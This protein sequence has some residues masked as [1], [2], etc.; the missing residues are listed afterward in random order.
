MSTLYGYVRVSTQHQEGGLDAQRRALVDA[1]VDAGHIYEDRI[2]GAS[3]GVERPGLSAAIGAC[4]ATAESTLVVWRV[5][6]LGRS[7]MDVLSTVEMLTERGV[8]LRSISD[9]VDPS[10]PTGALLLHLLLSVATYE[11][12]LTHERVNNGV[13]AAQARGVRFGRPAPDPVDVERRVRMAR[14]AIDEDGLSAAAAAELVG[15][16]RSTLYRH[17][18]TL[19][20]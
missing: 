11:R 18:A 3:A 19:A 13:R 17:M 6:R 5:D 10:T 20:A 2:T 4:L 8:A 7:M 15:W 14:R 16:S 1:G 12:L 9:G